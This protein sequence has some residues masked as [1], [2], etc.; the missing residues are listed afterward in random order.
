MLKLALGAS[1]G[2][3]TR[4]REV[5]GIV[6]TERSF[7][8]GLT[9]PS[10]EHE[11]YGFYVVLRGRFRELLRGRTWLSEPSMFVV[12]PPGEEH[13][14]SWIESGRILCAEFTR[15]WLERL[16]GS[17]G[18]L[19][20]SCQFSSGQIAR[21]GAELHAEFWREDAASSLALEGLAL[22]LAA[23]GVR[24]RSLKP[25]RQA[26]QWLI[27]AKELLYQ[28]IGEHVDHVSIARAVGVHPA[29]LSR[30]FRQHVGCTPGDYVRY[31]RME[32]AKCDLTLSDLSLSAIA[33][34]AGYSDQS[35]FSSAFRRLTG[36]TPGQFR[37][38]ARGCSIRAKTQM[39]GKTGTPAHGIVRPR[40]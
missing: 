6:F 38:A 3:I 14:D 29:H 21:L 15:S 12:T 19:S 36:A 27:Q 33:L 26:P 34:A 11:A 2:S 17:C 18:G 35:H 7:S 37:R 28:A 23:A 16:H 5:S 40:Q 10:H 4:R 25:Y 13:V 31:L 32:K 8:S 24:Q 9:T 39:S 30:T 22:E 1:Y 20:R